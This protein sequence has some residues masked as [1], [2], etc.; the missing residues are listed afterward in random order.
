M[1]NAEQLFGLSIS[2][3]WTDMIVRGF[4]TVEVRSW[5]AKRRGPIALQASLR[6]F[7]FSAAYFYGYRT[8]W[9]LQ[10][11]KIV[12][13]ADLVDVIKF[14]KASWQ[15]SITQHRQLLPNAGGLYGFVLTNIRQL[16]KPIRYNGRL[17]FFPIDDKT[18][19]RIWSDLAS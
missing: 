14:D 13:I 7:D 2:Q 3:P 9:E 5:E 12:A 10:R 8:P 1:S 16:K 6:S 18:T 15:S 19:Q 17:G 11:G 4:K